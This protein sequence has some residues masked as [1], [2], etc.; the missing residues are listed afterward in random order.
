MRHRTRTDTIECVTQI[1]LDRL[2]R[3][4]TAMAEQRID[5][6]L[7]SVGHDLPYLTGYLAMPL[8]RL[9][10]LVVPR[11]AAA[12]MLIPR[13][14]APRVDVQPGV[15]DLRPWDETDDPTA[16]AAGLIPGAERI[17]VGDQMWARFL[18]ELLPAQR[19]A[20]P[21]AGGCDGS[22]RSAGERVVRRR[23]AAHGHCARADQSTDP[24][25]V[26]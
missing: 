16:L 7:L 5:A 24:V 17:A 12:T 6:L 1:Y 23:T 22:G 11:D 14:E 18:V 25:V 20:R 8:E 15:F 4:R 9:T 10:M 21:G 19:G 26:R 3:V 2:E 13:L